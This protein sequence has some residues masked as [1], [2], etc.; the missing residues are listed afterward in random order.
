MEVNLNKRSLAE[1]I[2]FKLATTINK[3]AKTD[4][5]HFVKM[6]YGLEVLVINFSKIL[7]ILMIAEVL[8]ILTGTLLIMLSFASIRRYA[9]GI[10]AKSSISCT[11]ITCLCFFIGGYIPNF[12]TITNDEVLLMFLIT[13]SLLYLYAPADTEARPLVGKKLRNRLKIKVVL[14]GFILMILAFNINDSALKFFISYGALCESITITP[15][16]YKLFGRGYKNYERY[17]KV[18]D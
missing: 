14:L 1:R 17:K 9:F 8:G 11:I 3:N 16:I 7:L 5:L 4:N 12:L 18:I 13:I 15:I 2:A 10:H 6:K